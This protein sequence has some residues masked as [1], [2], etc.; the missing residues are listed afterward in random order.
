MYPVDGAVKQ[1]KVDL[2]WLKRCTANLCSRQKVVTLIIDGVKTWDRSE[3]Q[4]GQLIGLIE[5]G[6]HAKSVPAFMVPQSLGGKYKDVVFLA[7]TSCLDFTT[8]RQ[9]FD[10]VPRQLCEMLH[11]QA[12]SVDRSMY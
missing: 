7:P 11:V 10:R 8:L 9:Y 12:V 4:S 6:E 2:E 3:Y 1:C 5:N